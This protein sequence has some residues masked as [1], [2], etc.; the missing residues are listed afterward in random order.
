MA[1]AHEIGHLL[2]NQHGPWFY[3]VKIVRVERLET[4]CVIFW[5]SFVIQEHI[6]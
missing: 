4:D 2:M 6:F 1:L 3:A 5:K